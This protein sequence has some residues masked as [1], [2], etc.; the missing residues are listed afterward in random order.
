[1][2]MG[3]NKIGIQQE[4]ASLSAIFPFL[5]ETMRPWSKSVAVIIVGIFSSSIVF[6]S[7]LL[8]K[9]SIKLSSFSRPCL[10]IEKVVIIPRPKCS[11]WNPKRKWPATLV[12]QCC[13]D[14]ART[15]RRELQSTKVIYRQG[16]AA[17]EKLDG[18]VW[19]GSRLTHLRFHRRKAAVEGSLPETSRSPESRFDP[20][21]PVRQ[22]VF[23][24]QVSGQICH[25]CD[26]M[27]FVAPI[28]IAFISGKPKKVAQQVCRIFLQFLY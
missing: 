22:S 21:S 7:K 28:P 14:G 12:G 3:A 24:Q 5:K 25:R 13:S 17:L 2:R 15:E 18:R 16:R 9:K 19:V 11:Q 26:Q 20:L 8:F 4:A 27:A 6:D 1:M 23:Q 10:L